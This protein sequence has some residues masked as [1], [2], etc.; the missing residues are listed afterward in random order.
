MI[1]FGTNSED[2]DANVGERDRL[3]AGDEPPFGKIIVEK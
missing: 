2:R 1:A 3:T